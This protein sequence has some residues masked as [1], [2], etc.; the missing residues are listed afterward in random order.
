MYFGS[1]FNSISV[2]GSAKKEEF[3]MA[4]SF[5]DEVSHWSHT[6]SVSRLGLWSVGVS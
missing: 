2:R 3:L 6:K 1:H 5:Y 4:H